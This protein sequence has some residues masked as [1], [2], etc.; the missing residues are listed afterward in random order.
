AEYAVGRPPQG[1]P[2]RREPEGRPEA[3]LVRHREGRL[4]A[5]DLEGD[6][7]DAQGPRVPGRRSSDRRRP[8]LGQ[9]A[10]LPGRVRP[11]AVPRALTL[12]PRALPRPEARGALMDLRRAR[13]VYPAVGGTLRA[14]RASSPLSWW[15]RRSGD[16]MARPGTAPA[17][18]G[19]VG[20]L[21]RSRTT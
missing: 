10:R 4:P 13:A 3:R 19:L 17:G 16:K 6:G 8:H 20:C 1:D 11:A 12:P 2:R 7:G 9:L 15:R 14:R 21:G 18:A 5:G